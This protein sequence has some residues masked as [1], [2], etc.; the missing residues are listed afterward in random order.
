MPAL[1]HRSRPATPRRSGSVR[2]RL[3]VLVLVIAGVAVM[4]Y[5]SAA[6]WFSDLAHR[7][8]LQSYAEE[9]RD[10][11]PD[12]LARRLEAARE[13]NASLG[14]GA[15]RDPLSAAA[16]DPEAVSSA[17]RLL[18]NTSGGV[19]A[20]LRIPVIGAVLPV[21]SGTSDSVLERGIGH[22]P[23]SS[24][25]VGGAST[26]S[27]LTGHRGLPEST[28]FT[29]LDRVVEGDRFTVRTLGETLVY[30]VT[31]TQVV[32]PHDVEDLRIVADRD[33]VTLV[34]CTP[35]GVNSHRILVHA[36][37]VKDAGT[38]ADAGTAAAADAP[39]PV[40]FPWWALVVI[41]V[42]GGAC[43]LRLPRRD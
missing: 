25:P 12:E 20:E 9:I 33:L 38:D 27:V 31:S 39:V 18:A 8:R 1:P 40:A 30:R 15:V 3:L 34:T 43:I 6:S 14:A 23:G 11:P 13:F 28:L 2:S 19:I 36:E 21:Y 5:P 37:R 35:L 24:L 16:D 10:T 29:E 41:G 22:V 32:E 26:H 4:L 7:D 17:S 42:A